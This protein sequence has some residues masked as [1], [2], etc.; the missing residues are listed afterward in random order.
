MIGSWN[1][2]AKATADE[3][4]PGQHQPASSLPFMRD[5]PSEQQRVMNAS[6][7]AYSSS[8]QSAVQRVQHVTKI[9]HRHRGGGK[10]LNLATALLSHSK[11]ADIVSG[12]KRNGKAASPPVKRNTLVLQRFKAKARK[13]IEVE[14]DKKEADAKAHQHPRLDYLNAQAYEYLRKC[15]YTKQQIIKVQEKIIR[16][17]KSLGILWKLRRVHQQKKD[18]ERRWT[19]RDVE[20]REFDMVTAQKEW[21]VT[22]KKLEEEKN[23]VDEARRVNHSKR[24]SRE[25]I[26]IYIDKL[27]MQQERRVRK[28][29]EMEALTDVMEGEHVADI[30]ADRQTVLNGEMEYNMLC[31][32]CEQLERKGLD[33]RMK[34]TKHLIRKDGEITV[35]TVV[36]V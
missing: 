6:A 24:I 36:G 19:P 32:E 2:I 15:E 1:M 13:I 33:Q 5:E 4:I 29:H 30:R 18:H 12:N 34:E 16:S 31:R 9:I 20:H 28:V 21:S 27:V 11:L 25:Q 23:K 22:K 7:P 8:P 10:K 26:Q 3:V 14:R 17:K 35:R